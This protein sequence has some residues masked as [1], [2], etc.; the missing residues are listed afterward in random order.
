MVDEVRHEILQKFCISKEN[1]H[2][3][4]M[5]E[6]FSKWNYCLIL[7]DWRSIEMTKPNILYNGIEILNYNFI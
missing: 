1:L 7:F 4:Q 3:E 6:T 2:V 5:T